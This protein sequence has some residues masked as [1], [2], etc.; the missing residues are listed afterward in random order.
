[1]LGN[2]IFHIVKCCFNFLKWLGT[3]QSCQLI[4]DTTVVSAVDRHDRHAS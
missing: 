1:M 2:A 4:A 3:R